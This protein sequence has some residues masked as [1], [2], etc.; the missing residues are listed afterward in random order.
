MKTQI[1]SAFLLIT[2]LFFSVNKSYSNDLNA[3]KKKKKIEASVYQ[4]HG[5]HKLKL[6]VNGQKTLHITLKKANGEVFYSEDF[7]ESGFKYRRIFNLDEIADGNYVFEIRSGGELVTKQVQLS[8]N[9]ERFIA[10]N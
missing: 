5:T 9:Q 3:D 10:L 6:A 1:T 4:I 2:T 8:T 7:N